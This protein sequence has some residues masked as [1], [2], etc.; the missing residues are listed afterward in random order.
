MP[1]I[2]PPAILVL[3]NHAWAGELV[4]D[5]VPAS[6]NAVGSRGSWVA[7]ADQKKLWQGALEMLLMAARAPRGLAQGYAGAR[8]RLPTRRRRDSGNYSMMLE[9][10]LGDALVSYRA[11]ADDTATQFCFI[12]TEFE[13]TLGP[14]RTTI[15]LHLIDDRK[16]G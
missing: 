6:L 13:L 9:K 4:Y 15:V 2:P 8:V 1:G 3:P 14:P 10:A 12:G 5:D 11:I 7:F 16:E